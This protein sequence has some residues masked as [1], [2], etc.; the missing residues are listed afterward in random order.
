MGSTWLDAGEGQ[1]SRRWRAVRATC[2]GK[3]EQAAGGDTT[4]IGAHRILHVQKPRV[5]V[6]VL[7]NLQIITHPV[8]K[9]AFLLPSLGEAAQ[10]CSTGTPVDTW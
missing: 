10:L 2:G 3:A 9:G 7:K 5:W 4:S 6:S 8:L 1:F